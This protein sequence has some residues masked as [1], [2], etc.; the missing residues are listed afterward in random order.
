MDTYLLFVLAS[1]I[2]CIVPGP[3]MIF[4]L[5]CT[6]ARGRKAGILAAIGI[7]AGAYVHLFGAVLGL[8]ALLATSAYAFTILK[9]AGAL[10]LIYIGVQTLRSK[11]SAFSIEPG[12]LTQ[13]SDRQIFWQ[14][15]LSDVLNP[16]V[17]VFFLAFLPQFVDGASEHKTL[18][19]LFLGIT[20]NVIAILINV[21]LVY[22]AALLTSS[23]RANQ[24]ISSW[25]N[26]IMGS[27]FILLGLKLAN[28]KI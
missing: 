1:V 24:K 13:K 12:S 16:K 4:L 9:W 11:T 18:D 25:L 7:N 3:D 10:Y 23:L 26:K 27:V 22:A 6:L 15:F 8:S 5:S 2:L 28:E 14:G 17:A 20:V 19:I 21:A